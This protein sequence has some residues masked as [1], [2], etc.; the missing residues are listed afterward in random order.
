MLLMLGQD[1]E[2][3]N[4][5]CLYIKYYMPGIFFYG[6]CDLYKKFL[7]SH[8]KNFLPMIS[9]SISVLIHPLWLTLFME[10]Y[11]MGIVGIAL[12]ATI[13]NTISYILMKIL[14]HCMDDLKESNFLPDK[15]VFIDLGYYI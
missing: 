11:Q 5:T 7:N 12:A 14:Y 9:L 13:T 1:P 10:K 15:R 3:V 2:V 6:I 8:G 4:L